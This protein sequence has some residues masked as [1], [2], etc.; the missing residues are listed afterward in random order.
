MQA[1]RVVV[2]GT[3]GTI[4]GVGSSVADLVGYRSAALDVAD[5][6]A[7]VPTLAGQRLQAETLARL[8]SSDMDHETWAMLHARLAELMQ[9][10]DVAGV[11][12]THGTDTLEETAYF[13]HRTL[14][15]PRPLVLTAAMR[16][17]SALSADGPRNLEDAVTLAR[18]AGVRGVVVVFGGRV[19]AGHDVR[20][21]HGFALEAFRSGDAGPL[22]IL[23][24]GALRQLRAWPEAPLHAAAT[25]L[26]G[27]LDALPD[28]SG[29]AAGERLR[30]PRVDIVTGHAGADGRVIDALVAAGS[31]GIVVAGT[32][33]GGVHRTL[34]A[35]ARRALAAGVRVVRASRCQLG[36][37]VGAVP[38]ALPS[39][40]VLT[41]A[42]ARVE[43]LLDLLAD[44]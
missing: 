33:N 28:G 6:V 29:G 9:C 14:A 16:P 44:A 13:L 43:L 10:S 39:Y 35:A 8:D 1:N 41:A 2:V 42:Q 37:V 15:A 22:G 19:L 30:W 25:R 26:R 3:G 36:G 34:A 4:A 11:V 27:M 31:E 20:K 17:A 12:V 18:T 23:E 24:Q 7:A 5:L 32:G 21:V 40:G 38:D